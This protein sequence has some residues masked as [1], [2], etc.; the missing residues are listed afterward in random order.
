MKKKGSKDSVKIKTG[1]EKTGQ[2]D[3]RKKKGLKA[4]RS[5]RKKGYRRQKLTKTGVKEDG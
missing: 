3:E 5:G 2:V 4:A 1:L